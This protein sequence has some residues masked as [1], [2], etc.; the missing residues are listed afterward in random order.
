MES[1]FQRMQREATQRLREMSAHAKKEE[2]T[3]AVPPQREPETKKPQKKNNNPL[4]IFSSLFS[5]SGDGML[6]AGIL[7]L[8]HRDKGDDL[9]MLALLYILM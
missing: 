6:L 3:E 1:D 4:D 5:G 9:L 2:N 8:L 7:L